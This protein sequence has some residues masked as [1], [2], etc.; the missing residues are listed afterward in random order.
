MV[1]QVPN[2]RLFHQAWEVCGEAGF[3]PY[4]LPGSE[5][6]GANIARTF[7]D[8]YHCVILENHGVVVGGDTL[9]QAFQ[10]F[11]TLEFTAKTIIKASMLGRGPL[12]ERRATRAWPRR[13][14]EPLPGLQ[15][16]APPAA[17]RRS[18][19]GSC[20]TFSAAATAIAC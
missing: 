1:G 3:A 8:G 9:Q 5:R 17:R 14:S 2:T 4:A 15:P 12:P 19:G 18:S 13:A 20:A 7:Q 16:P 11:E 6:L 10:R